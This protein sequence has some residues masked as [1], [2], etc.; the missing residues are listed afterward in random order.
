MQEFNVIV[1]KSRFYREADTPAF[2]RYVYTHDVHTLEE[3]CRP[4]YWGLLYAELRA[5]DM[6]YV[7]DGNM[8][9]TTL[10][11]EEI[12]DINN[13]V[14]LSMEKEHDFVPLLENGQTL[15]YRWKGRGGGHCII[16][17]VGNVVRKD[18]RSKSTALDLIA[19]LQR[20]VEA[21]QDSL[22]HPSDDQLP[23]ADAA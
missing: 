20:R 11:V 4:K 21:E 17:A 8:K 10:L 3:M 7:V 12:D 22:A 16:D 13:N 5:G 6:I 23:N 15:A 19:D 2:C 1:D 18:L 9:R 14:I